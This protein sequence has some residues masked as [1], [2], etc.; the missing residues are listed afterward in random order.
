MA[1]CAPM[2]F[3]CICF[4]GELTRAGRESRRRG[5]LEPACNAPQE[6]RCTHSSPVVPSR[7]EHDHIRFHHRRATTD[8]VELRTVPTFT[9]IVHSWERQVIALVRTPMERSTPLL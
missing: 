7:I 9:A 1:A 3:G 5:P 6:T 8:A 2:A 4:L